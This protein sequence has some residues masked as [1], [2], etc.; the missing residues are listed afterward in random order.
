MST[1]KN[2]IFRSDSKKAVLEDLFLFLDATVNINA[3]DLCVFDDTNKLVVP[4][5]GDPGDGAL[6]LGISPVTIVNG[7]LKSPY[8]GTAV[9]ASEKNTGSVGPFYGVTAKLIL[10]TGDNFVK[11][12]L[13]YLSATDPQNVQVTANGTAIGIFVDNTVASAAAGQE[14]LVKLTSNFRSMSF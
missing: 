13:V 4:T 2:R 1:P 12:G 14:G 6:F 3:G 5:T 10:E 8:Q 9:D 11:G 7:N